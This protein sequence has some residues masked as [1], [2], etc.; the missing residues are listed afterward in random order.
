MYVEIDNKNY[1]WKLKDYHYILAAELFA[2][3]KATNL[4]INNTGLHFLTFLNRKMKSSA[5][6]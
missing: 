2:L 1:R 4:S 3:Q 6:W 5:F